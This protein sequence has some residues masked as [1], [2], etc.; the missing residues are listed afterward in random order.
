MA[1]F[2]LELVSCSSDFDKQF[3]L[4]AVRE[5]YGSTDAFTQYVRGPLR[6]ELV[7]VVAEMRAPMSYCLLAFS[8]AAGIYADVL[9]SLWLAGASNE[10]L[11]AYVLGQVLS[12]FLLGMAQIKVLFILARRYSQPR[13]LSRTMDYMQSGG[14][15]LVWVLFVAASFPRNEVYYKFGVPGAVAALIVSML[16]F[17]AMFFRD[18]QRFWG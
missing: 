4:A 11:L 7:Q 9:G 18:F 3:I 5:W 13:F 10:M 6:D 16:V 1:N 17:I 2:D 12:S 15:L 8:P 14:V